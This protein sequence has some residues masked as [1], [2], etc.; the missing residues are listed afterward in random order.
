M[1]CLKESFYTSTFNYEG[2]TSLVNI[3]VLAIL[4]PLQLMF[5]ICMV[6]ILCKTGRIEP[7]HSKQ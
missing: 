4:L 1:S 6:G 3:I 7:L 5:A 2:D